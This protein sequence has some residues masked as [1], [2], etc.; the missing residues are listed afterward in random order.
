MRITKLLK[1]CAISLLI[2]T[3][4]IQAK[5]I[6]VYFG[7]VEKGET[8]LD[9]HFIK[10][11]KKAK[12]TIDAAFYELRD[13]NIMNE[14]I[15]AHE[16][17]VE[18]RLIVDSHNFFLRDHDTLEFDF[19]KRNKFVKPLL[20]AGIVVKYDLSSKVDEET[21][22]NK[23]R[24]GLMHNKFCVL[25]S[26][27]VWTGSY[28]L[29]DTGTHKNENNA[30][31]VVNKKLAAI[32]TREFVEMYEDGAYGI[33]SPSTAEDQQIKVGKTPVEVYFAP[34][35]DP[36]GKIEVEINSAEESVYF[37][38]FAMTSDELGDALI[39]K[40]ESGLK[41]KG[42]FDRML[43]RS[44]GP[45]AEFS[46]LTQ[47]DI[48]VIVYDSPTGGKLHHKVFIIDAEGENP[49]VI[50]GS[51]NASKNGNKMN[52]E[53]IVIIR[54]KEVT[55]KYFNEFNKLFGRLSRV[56]A[57]FKS[58]KKALFIDQ[59][60]D[61]L[62]LVISTN[63]IPTDELKIQF[64]ARWG[65]IN[66]AEEEVEG[67]ESTEPAVEASVEIYR[68]K[69]G[70][71]IKS[72]SKE[73]MYLSQRDITLKNL[74]LKRK[75]E[76]ALLIIKC[77]NFKTPSIPGFYNMY[78]QAKSKTGKM[79]PLKFQPALHVMDPEDTEVVANEQLTNILLG[80]LYDG[81]YKS[82]FGLVDSCE[83]DDNN[84]GILTYGS[85]L[86]RA[87][88][89]INQ[90]ILIKNEDEAKEVLK[91]LKRYQTTFSSQKAPKFN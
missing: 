49:R 32:F 51:L 73:T 61:R 78:I 40:R 17:G 18:V 91:R 77:K 42:M 65:D 72:T 88:R 9:Q 33:S 13:E 83:N 8:R 6:N 89:I 39:N 52:D 44:T 90:R 7:P 56:T 10:Y 60:I 14:F 23:G 54:D 19:D 87:I 4:S 2:N 35:D 67:E 43:Y 68:M 64:P 11:L 48:P 66:K 21:G 22:I 80:K 81:K 74:N 47:N 50:F 62:D 71:Q 25:D 84:C 86:K 20:D 12:K 69:N 16:R 85:F 59:K 28:N 53:N 75:G 1:V 79:Y 36:V 57:G 76:D 55:T 31:E 15:A 24:S 29:S 63:G 82:F 30:I 46:R 38:Q 37:M 5:G 70:K 34:E 27:H 26:K 45:Y 41:V 58:Q 3:T